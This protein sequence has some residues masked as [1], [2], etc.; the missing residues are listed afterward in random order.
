MSRVSS[1]KSRK[2]SIVTEVFFITRA[3]MIVGGC[4]GPC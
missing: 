4:P 3:A 2:D 1:N